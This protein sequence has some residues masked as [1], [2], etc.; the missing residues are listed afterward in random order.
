MNS[1]IVLTGLMGAGKSTVGKLLAELLE[2]YY[3]VDIDDEI[4]RREG[5]SISDIFSTKSEEYFRSVETGIIK[6]FAHQKNYIISIGGG[7]F[8]F[9]ENRTVLL[10]N[11]VVF[12]LYASAQTLFDRIKT[13]NSRPLLVC[14]NPL[15]K[16]SDLLKIREKNYKQ[17]D[18]IID[19]TDKTIE[20]IT[21][22][23]LEKI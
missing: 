15:Q 20:N 16:L 2:D 13:D 9:E 18:F 4:V 7:A 3:F 19:T 11:G 17:A 14:D 12:Y 10:K 23:I 1:N 6:E 22:E 8:E 5:I 21:K